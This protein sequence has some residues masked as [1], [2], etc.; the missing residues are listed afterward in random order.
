MVVILWITLPLVL[1]R[2]I[3]KL[4]FFLFYMK[5]DYNTMQRVLSWIFYLGF[6]ISAILG[7][8]WL[9]KLLINVIF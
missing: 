4:H 8:T 1:G 7:F 3:Y 5:E 9:I 6:S 2:N